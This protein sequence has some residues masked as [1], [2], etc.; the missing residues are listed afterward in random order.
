MNPVNSGKEPQPA[1][2]KPG[3]KD[4]FLKTAGA[5]IGGLGIGGAMVVIGSAVLWI[6]FKEAGLPPIQAVS[7]QPNHEALV[8]GAQVTVVFVLIAVLVV[9]ALYISDFR[10]EGEAKGTAGSDEE[11]DPDPSVKRPIMARTKWLLGVPPLLGI[12]WMVSFT[13]L[14]VLWVLALSV[15]AVA[16]GLACL[17]VGI[18]ESKNF[19][20]LAAAVF[21]AVIVF[22]GAAGYAIVQ[23]QKFVQAV[24][25][26]RG[27]NDA[28]L[29]G[30]YVAAT[31]KKIYFANSIGTD[32]RAAPERKPMQEVALNEAV[33]YSVGPL[34]SA[35]DATARAQAMLRRLVADRESS[36]AGASTAGK[37][38]L[39]SWVS[40]KV[41]ATFTEMAKAHEKADDSLCLM[42]YLEAGKGA[43]KGPWWTSCK[44]AEAIAT[45]DDVRE[46]LALPWRFQKAYDVRVKVEVPTGTALKYVAGDTAPQ[47]GGAPGKPCGHRYPGGGLQ[48]WIS[49]PAALGAVSRE[50]T[51]A[52]PDEVSEWHAC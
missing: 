37:A 11:N 43:E 48:Y 13:D 3:I 17:W 41:A 15:L 18:S 45:V 29:T 8:Q 36:T 10:E 14:G 32:G 33:T 22:A 39:P 12:I 46:R 26:L 49:E 27:E 38:D 2:E 51:T 40:R 1:G 34:E 52:D 5:V 30:Y 23:E 47:C 4:W 31:D 44:E 7:V 19:W 25:I 21:V 35:A 42:R 16:L 20:A 9:V 28:G 6:R 50:C 24:A